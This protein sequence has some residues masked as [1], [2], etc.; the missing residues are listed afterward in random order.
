MRKI[1]NGK[2]YD[3]ETA[4]K[5]GYWESSDNPSDIHYREET[6]Y[7]KKTG[8][9]FLWSD[10]GTAAPWGHTSTCLPLTL[11]EAKTWAENCISA[12]E[13]EKEFGK[14]EE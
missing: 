7:R 12:E 1:I 4:T 5:I 10:C 2:A 3:T 14:V 6:L 8:E 9:Y 13:Y 11:G